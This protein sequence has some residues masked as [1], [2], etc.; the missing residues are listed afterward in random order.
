[1]RLGKRLGRLGRSVGRRVSSFVGGGGRR[2]IVRNYDSSSKMRVYND[3]VRK[4][5][6]TEKAL[7]GYKANLSQLA[8]KLKESGYEVDNK[9]LQN[10]SGKFG[11]KW[12]IQEF[13]DGKVFYKEEDI[14]NGR[15][16]TKSKIRW[17]IGSDGT[18][19]FPVIDKTIGKIEG[20]DAFSKAWLESVKKNGVTYDIG[21]LTQSRSEAIRKSMKSKIE[22]EYIPKVKNMQQKLRAMKQVG[23]IL[24]I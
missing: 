23:T 10:M 20:L 22:Q 9:V 2:D 7:E 11:L 12:M 5:K 19:L 21:F 14:I 6:S 24:P 15:K 16:F 8:M 13:S 17:V 18:V 1:M 3:L 4:I